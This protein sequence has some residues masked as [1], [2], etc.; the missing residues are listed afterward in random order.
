MTTGMHAPA[1]A[2][3]DEHGM[4]G[5]YWV[6]AVARA[7]RPAPAVL[8]EYTIATTAR[9]A[10][11]I[12]GDLSDVAVDEKRGYAT[13]TVGDVMGKGL[14]S[15]VLAANLLGSLEVFRQEPPGEAVDAAETATRDH[16]ERASAFA[17]LFHARLRFRDGRIEFVDA[18]HGL[19]AHA[20]TSGAVERIPSAD[21]PIGLQ[22]AGMPR[23]PR[24]L[25]LAPGELLLIVSDG[26]FELPGAT[27]DTLTQ[28]ATNL[29]TAPDL[30]LALSA[31]MKAA[32]PN[33]DDDTTLTAIR[34]HP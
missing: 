15:G 25:H 13:I 11:G 19:T 21:F 10:R 29:R 9:S 34:R 3:D 18:G 16:F 22:P 4:S 8:D 7:M 6:D 17:T 32:G 30:Q 31:F 26:L 2:G 20:H 28:L 27:I 24:I 1:A 5:A 23:L 12:S 33:L 14:A